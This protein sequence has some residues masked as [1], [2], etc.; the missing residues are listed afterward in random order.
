M[1]LYTMQIRFTKGS[2]E[3]IVQYAARVHLNDVTENDRRNALCSHFYA[4][5]SAKKLCNAGYKA[6]PVKISEL[7]AKDYE[8]YIEVFSPEVLI[9]GSPVVQ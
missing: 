3:T 4:S 2:I 8:E 6:S 7:G 5:R 1:K 9:I